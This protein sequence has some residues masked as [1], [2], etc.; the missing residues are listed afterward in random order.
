VQSFVAG[1]DV[2]LSILLLQGGE[3]VVPDAGSLQWELRGQNGAILSPRTTQAC[4]ET[5]V[6]VTINA[7][8]NAITLP[9]EKRTVAVYWTINGFPMV[10]RV[11]YRLTAFLNHTITED[12]VRN[13]V[14]L[15]ADALPDEDVDIIQAY[16]DCSALLGDA[17]LLPNALINGGDNE[18]AANRAIQAQSV[19]NLMPSLQARFLAREADGQRQIENL[20]IDLADLEHRASDQLTRAIN[21]VGSR[22]YTPPTFTVA[23]VMTDVITG[24]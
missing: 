2:G 16:F 21:Q 20:P 24:A 3:P 19:L 17:T 14:G 8:H 22:S 5:S 13:F 6:L 7:S 23:G 10:N 18:R 4:T 15:E 11:S 1:N 9:F 12:D